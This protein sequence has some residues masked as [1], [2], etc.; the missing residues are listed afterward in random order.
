[1][2]PKRRVDGEVTEAV[3]P[4]KV[5]PRDALQKS[6]T[7]GEP[8]AKPALKVNKLDNSA[9]VTRLSQHSYIAG[10]VGAFTI[11]LMGY[12]A[13][14]RDALVKGWGILGGEPDASLAMAFALLVTGAVMFAVELGVRIKVDRGRIISVPDEIRE[15]KWGPFLGR[16]FTIWVIDLGLLTAALTIYKYANEY[17]FQRTADYYKPWFAVME[18]FRSIYLYGGLPYV[19][20]T[21]ALQH[22]ARSDRKQA[23]FTVM[24][25][26]RRIGA[27]ITKRLP[28]APAFDRYDKS[29]MAGLGVKLF[30]VPLMTVFFS[31]Q[32]SHLIK[33]WRFMLDALADSGHK[34][35]IGDFHNVSYTVIFSIDVGLA[36]AG[37]VLSTRWIK[38]TLFS[39]EPSV[40][41]WM[42]A[43]MSYPPFNRVFGFYL[44]TPSE[45]GFMG[46]KSHAAVTL[47][48]VM[49][50]MSFCVYTSATVCFGLRFSNLTHRGIIT[51][52]PYAVVR[53]PAYAAKNFSWWC[54]MMP[55]A[56][57]DAGTHP[58]YL[59]AIQLTGLVAMSSIYYWRAITEERHLARDPEYQAYM[60]KVP[61]RF[62]P[63]VI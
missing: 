57:Y 19:V 42:V 25:A 2:K 20:L 46:M 47:L 63:G 27:A 4:R 30:F 14:K 37:Y 50:V 16:C 10:I 5:G 32:F 44:S 39:V 55:F 35:S 48:A 51:T 28:P 56:F 43:L 54:V 61:W 21:R 26:A 9:S 38:N 23:A 59:L 18:I 24:K 33:N 53:H 6:E 45:S 7:D 62:I 22:D 49:S 34:Y 17:G 40:L 3:S 29:A 41:G 13:S 58:T 36:W 31:D 52:G 12:L 1:M 8:A 60:K 11:L 15:G